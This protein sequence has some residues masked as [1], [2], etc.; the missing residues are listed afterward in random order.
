MPTN[1]G[2]LAKPHDAP[3]LEAIKRRSPNTAIVLLSG[4]SSAALVVKSL[5]D[6]GADGFLDKDVAPEQICQAIARVRRGSRY[7][8]PR[9]QAAIDLLNVGS[10]ESIRTQ[11]LKGRRGDVL[12]LLLEGFS[13]T[14]IAEILPV[15]KKHVDKKIAEIKSILGVKI[16]IRILRVCIKLGITDDMVAAQCP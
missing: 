15:G 2:D 11:L 10:G 1:S 8:V 6:S 7:V 12:R 13:P 3:S 16:H 14:E 9:L 5:L 4:K